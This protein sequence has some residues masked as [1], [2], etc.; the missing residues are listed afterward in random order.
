MIQSQA[1]TMGGLFGCWKAMT[2][3]PS[4]VCLST[5][6][7]PSSRLGQVWA[8]SH[9]GLCRGAAEAGPAARW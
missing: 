7:Q 8:W 3:D 4:G 5:G 6:R 2:A 1:F 9:L